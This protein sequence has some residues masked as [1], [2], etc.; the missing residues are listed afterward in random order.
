MDSYDM[1]SAMTR[2]ISLNGYNYCRHASHATL[3]DVQE[4]TTKSGV[5]TFARKLVSGTFRKRSILIQ[6]INPFFFVTSK[7]W[8]IIWPCLEGLCFPQRPWLLPEARRAQLCRP[9]TRDSLFK[10]RSPVWRSE[11]PLRISLSALQ[12]L[13]SNSLLMLARLSVCIV[14][15]SI[16]AIQMRISENR[17]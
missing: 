1:D 4:L 3:L 5:K 11:Q 14:L 10:P 12:S 13:V 15:L 9:G 17:D 2:I 7:A 6:Q 8:L 16:C